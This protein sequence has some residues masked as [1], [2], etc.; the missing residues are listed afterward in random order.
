MPARW[1]HDQSFLPDGPTFRTLWPFSGMPAISR[2][3]LL[4][5]LAPPV[6]KLKNA[7]LIAVVLIG[8]GMA[9][10]EYIENLRGKDD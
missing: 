6:I 9:V 1:E 5:Y 10:Y 8:A 7:A 3:L 4:A 2:F